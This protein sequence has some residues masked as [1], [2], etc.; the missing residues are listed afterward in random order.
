MKKQPLVSIIILGWNNYED[1][2]NC[3]N[4]I[5]YI[6]Y[7]NFNIILIDNNSVENNFQKM[8]SWLKKTKTQHTMLES[9]DFKNTP[10]TPKN[11]LVVVKS[12]K[13]LGFAG[14]N[15][16]GYNIAIQMFDPKY[17]LLLNGD[18][19]VTEDFLTKLIE[20]CE[21]DKRIGSA[22]SV[23]LRFDKKTIDSLGLEMR[24]HRIF[25]AGGGRD[26]SML[27]NVEATK[28]IFGVC[29][30]AA[31]YR[32]DLI[33][34]IGLFDAGLFATFEDF[35]LAWRIRLSG[36]KSFLANKSIVYHRGGVS[37]HKLDHVIFDRRSYYA[38][39]NLLVVYNRYYP[40][41][42]PI[43]ANS[44]VWFGIGII[45]ALKVNRIREFF[46]ALYNSYQERRCISKNNLLRRV[47]HDWIVE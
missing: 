14:G 39:R 29:G 16:L 42:L 34:K 46:S 40:R 12:D 11:N 35:D 37:R 10:V 6:D 33:N 2:I 24:G 47:R 3:L 22:Q 9:T 25:D 31:L 13:N 18:T 23:L 26:V 17:L 27:E 1:I 45:S 38:A 44:I 19:L 8:T 30:A 21:N 4:S 20:I 43:L 28:E 41:N 36:Y 5:K 32:T 15:N 7:K